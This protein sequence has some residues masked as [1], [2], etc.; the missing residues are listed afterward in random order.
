MLRR[1]MGL[2]CRVK[3]VVKLLVR[4]LLAPADKVTPHENAACYAYRQ[5][6]L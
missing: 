1:R 6:M 5:M 4:P 3:E 2:R